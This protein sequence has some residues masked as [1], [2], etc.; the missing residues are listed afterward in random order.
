MNFLD[1]PQARVA[2]GSLS[3]FLSSREAVNLSALVIVSFSLGITASN[4]AI[5]FS[6]VTRPMSTF[7]FTSLWARDSLYFSLLTEIA[8]SFHASLEIPLIRELRVSTAA[9]ASIAVPSAPIFS[10]NSLETGA[11]P[12][13]TT[14]ESL[15]PSS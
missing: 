10:A 7:S 12:T 4:S 3:T 1:T 9:L 15:I 6:A 14:S 13:N 11:P 2:I 5:I 8:E